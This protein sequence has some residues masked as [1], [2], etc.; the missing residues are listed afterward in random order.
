VCSGDRVEA[1][2]L[3]SHASVYPVHDG[4]P[5]FVWSRATRDRF[6][7]RWRGQLASKAGDP[8]LRSFAAVDPVLTPTQALYDFQWRRLDLA[9]AERNR[10]QVERHLGRSDSLPQ[11]GL[12]LEIGCGN[13][14]HSS[15]LAAYAARVVA[16]DFGDQIEMAAERTADPKIS[17]VQASAL[18]LPFADARCGLVF[19]SGVL[20]HTPSTRSAFAEACRVLSPGGRVSCWVYSRWRWPMLERLSDLVRAGTTRLPHRIVLAFAYLA[21]PA[22]PLARRLLGYEFQQ[23]QPTY[24]DAVYYLFDW[25]TPEFQWKHTN[26]ELRAWATEEG[27]L[28]VRELHP[29]AGIVAERPGS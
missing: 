3:W 29:P 14:R 21:A 22:L 20:M 7:D 26:D 18:R 17:F 4:I 28:V 19:T 11:A 16:V 8:R 1:G 2:L 12:A 13:G 6:L 5:R 24:R 9:D 10:Q 23:G 15:A 25:F 27:L